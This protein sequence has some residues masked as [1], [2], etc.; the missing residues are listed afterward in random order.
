MSIFGGGG[1]VGLARKFQPSH[2]VSYL[3]Q[4]PI[5]PGSDLRTLLSPRNAV[6]SLVKSKPIGQS[7]GLWG[8][9]SKLGTMENAMQKDWVRAAEH[10][11]QLSSVLPAIDPAS[12]HFRAWLSGDKSYTP[13]GDI[14]SAHNTGLSQQQ[15][16]NLASAVALAAM[17]GGMFGGSGSG[18]AGGASG[19]GEAGTGAAGTG[20]AGAGTGAGTS[21]GWESLLSSMPNPMGGQQQSGP[22]Q[23][24]ITQQQMQQQTQQLMQNQQNM[25]DAM[26][27]QRLANL[28]NQINTQN[29]LNMGGGL[30]G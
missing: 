30:Y 17:G 5:A 10:P 8:E 13:G 12:A 26:K 15:E 7:L 18:A 22:T 27:N 2:V 21:S 9:N 6:T 16:M 3:K 29:N 1:L 4:S 25:Q 19:A 11:G 28:L 23:G 24:Q 14:G 20:T